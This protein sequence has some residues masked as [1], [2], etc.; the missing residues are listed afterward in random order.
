MAFGLSFFNFA[1]SSFMLNGGKNGS[2]ANS[3]VKWEPWDIHMAVLWLTLN[4]STRAGL[5]G[6]RSWDSGA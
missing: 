1:D 4:N 6:E 3:W 2:A 5:T